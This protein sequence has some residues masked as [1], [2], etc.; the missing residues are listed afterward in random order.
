MTAVLRA[1]PSVAKMI[2]W[3]TGK[4]FAT[5]SWTQVLRNVRSP[6]R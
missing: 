3:S 2:T 6:S 1:A 5:A 4:N